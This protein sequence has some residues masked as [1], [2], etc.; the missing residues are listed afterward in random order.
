[1]E[2]ETPYEESELEAVATALLIL[3]GKLIA[4]LLSIMID[5]L[6]GMLSSSTD[7]SSFSADPFFGADPGNENGE[8]DD[9]FYWDDRG[10]GGTWFSG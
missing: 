2:N 5:M 3:V 4:L 7:S 1:M 6:V 9:V 10:S 8:I